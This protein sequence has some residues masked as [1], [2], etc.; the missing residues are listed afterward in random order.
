MWL[1]MLRVIGRPELADDPRF[2][3]DKARWENREALNAI[4]REW[5]GAHTKHEAMRLLAAAGVPSGAVQDTGEVL[6]DPHLRERGMIVDIDYPTRGAYQTVGCPIKL[7]DSP[8]EV[9]RPPLLGEHTVEL[10]GQLCGVD[11]H[12]VERLRTAGVV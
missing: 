8:A 5:T 3:E 9:T 10:L 1:A 6:T 7:S 11:E 12:K 4:I 2:A